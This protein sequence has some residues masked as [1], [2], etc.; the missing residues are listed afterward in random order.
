[1]ADVRRHLPGAQ[2]IGLLLV[3]AALP[4]GAPAALAHNSVDDL[5]PAPGTVVESSPVGVS[6][7][8]NDTLLDLAGDSRGFVVVALDSEGAYFGDGC[9]EIDER[10]MTAE[11]ALGEAGTYTIAYQFVSAD[12]HSVSNSYTIEFEPGPSHS[13]TPGVATPPLCGEAPG[14]TEAITAPHA[15]APSDV[16]APGPRVVSVVGISL[17]AVVAVGLVVWAARARNRRG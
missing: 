17:L 8:T 5:V 12:G 16:A 10:Q 13:P 1:M 14:A 9:V 4:L 6:I 2:L 7:T 15:A 11:L 3:V